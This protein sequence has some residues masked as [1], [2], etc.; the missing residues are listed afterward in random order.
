MKKILYILP[1]ILLGCGDIDQNQQELNVWLKTAKRP[2]VTKWQT[3]SDNHYDQDVILV[4]AEGS[5]LLLHECELTIPD[6]I[7]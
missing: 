7:K 5:L 1:L 4:D 2:I 3:K 6:T